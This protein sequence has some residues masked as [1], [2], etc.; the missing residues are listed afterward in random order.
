MSENLK[1]ENM[2]IT[3][4]S[5]TKE[6]I[7]KIC[8]SIGLTS[9][10]LIDRLI[11]RWE[12]QEPMCAAQLI[13]DNIYINTRK[14]NNSQFDKTIAIVFTVIKECLN[15]DGLKSLAPII[16]DFDALLAKKEISISEYDISNKFMQKWALCAAAVSAGVF[17]FW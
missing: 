3:V 14:M 4:L 12:P 13:L 9:G 6:V 15:K 16:E 2:E 17:L 7:E 5:N 10:E 1:L 11:L 8:K